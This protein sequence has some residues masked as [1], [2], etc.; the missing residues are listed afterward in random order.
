MRISQDLD[1]RLKLGNLV[2]AAIFSIVPTSMTIG[3]LAVHG[4]L[5]CRS[6]DS[7]LEQ[8]ER[9]VVSNLCKQSNIEAN[10]NYILWVWIFTM[11]PT[12]RWFYIGHYRRI[13][14]TSSKDS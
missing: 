10:Y 13:A 4:H 9:L 6:L 2:L 14:N 5:L 1:L 7:R 3:F 12:W 8:K 11:I